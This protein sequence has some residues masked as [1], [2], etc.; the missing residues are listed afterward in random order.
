MRNPP[1]LGGSAQARH[2]PPPAPPTPTTT[3]RMHWARRPYI[4]LFKPANRSLHR[5]RRA[6][7]KFEAG[8]V[9]GTS[10]PLG[11]RGSSW[12]RAGVGRVPLRAPS[13]LQLGRGH[14]GNKPQ[15]PQSGPRAENSVVPIRGVQAW[16][17]PASLPELPA[18][19]RA[20]SGRA[21]RRVSSC[22]SG[23]LWLPFS[24]TWP[25]PPARSVPIR[26]AA[27]HAAGS[28]WGRR[29]RGPGFR[30]LLTSVPLLPAGT[31]R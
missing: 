12:A 23:G 14:S 30:D 9:V 8:P 28:H 25:Q 3:P 11:V 19:R 5:A 15:S 18:W 2:A 7:F 26:A 27:A 20:A 6:A 13:G 10:Q 16:L 21:S 24:L 22:M 29:N 31:S 1:A 17:G 4:A